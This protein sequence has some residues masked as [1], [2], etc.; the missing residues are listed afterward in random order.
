MQEITSM[1]VTE[2]ILS[3]AKYHPVDP[4]LKKVLIPYI[5]SKRTSVGFSSWYSGGTY[6]QALYFPPSAT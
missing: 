6:K 5:R 1:I 2:K 4:W 3:G